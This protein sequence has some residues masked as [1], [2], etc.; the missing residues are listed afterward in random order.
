MGRMTLGVAIGLTSATVP[1][2]VAEVAPPAVRGGLVTANDLMI[3]L[4]QVRG[5]SLPSI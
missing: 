1:M 5:V 2:Y 3:C 4:G